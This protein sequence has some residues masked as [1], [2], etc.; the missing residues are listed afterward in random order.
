M[1]PSVS[2]I[3]VCTVKAKV[4]WLVVNCHF[5]AHL[6]LIE[7][8][9]VLL[10]SKVRAFGSEAA[11][12]LPPPLILGLWSAVIDSLSQSGL[13]DKEG[14][15]EGTDEGTPIL[16]WMDPSHV[17]TLSQSEPHDKVGKEGTEEKTKEGTGCDVSPSF[18]Y[19][20]D[21]FLYT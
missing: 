21:D 20:A 13:R 1:T 18:G 17:I 5:L 10:L 9:D 8:C 15:E 3:K 12:R 6:K 14:T 19:L 2:S 11:P 4:L 16:S 7:P